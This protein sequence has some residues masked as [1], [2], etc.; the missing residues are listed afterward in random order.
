MQQIRKL[1]CFGYPGVLSSNDSVRKQTLLSVYMCDFYV[2]FIS[3]SA[4]QTM[5]MHFLIN[6]LLLTPLIFFV[7]KNPGNLM[8]CAL[9]QET[10]YI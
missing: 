8:D 3:F 6:D 7:I 10:K 2:C 9:I 4:S 1:V 5:K